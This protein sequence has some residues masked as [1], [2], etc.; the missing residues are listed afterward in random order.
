MFIYSCPQGFD[1]KDNEDGF[2]PLFLINILG[3]CILTFDHFLKADKKKGNGPLHLFGDLNQSATS[4][5]QIQNSF[6]KVVGKY[7]FVHSI[8]FL[9]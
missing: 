5:Q 8:E 4:L 7:L 2:E 1:E 3:E 6:E 9:G